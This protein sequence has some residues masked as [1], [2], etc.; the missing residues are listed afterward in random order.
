MLH[1]GLSPL[2]HG[3]IFAPPE[4]KIA[5]AHLKFE[6]VELIPQQILLSE[7]IAMNYVYLIQHGLV[8]LLRS[9]Q[10]GATVEVGVVGRNGFAGVEIALG[11]NTSR[12][13]GVVQ[14]GGSALRIGAR[15]FRDE[16]TRSRILQSHLRNCAYDL[17]VQISRTAACNARHTIKKRLASWI[18]KARDRTGEDALPMSHELLSTIL[19]TRRAGI[20]VALG[21]L[22]SAGLISNNLGR[23]AILDAAGLEAVACRCYGVMQ[24][25]VPEV[26][27]VGAAADVE[28]KLTIDPGDLSSIA[29]E[30]F[31]PS[32]YYPAP[33]NHDISRR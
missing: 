10:D 5:L 27:T 14:I 25:N 12:F 33:E 32:A 11:S 28:R 18:L 3:V 13:E 23:I 2:A 31:D 8:S 1:T 7:G 4:P 19:G 9:M 6:E 22:R 15:T 17:L 29:P 16:L 24:D 26:F 21:K 20:T 30:R